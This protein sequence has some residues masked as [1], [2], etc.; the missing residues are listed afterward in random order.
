MVR[1]IFLKIKEQLDDESHPIVWIILRFQDAFKR[2]VEAEIAQI[3]TECMD[4]EDT[5]RNQNVVSMPQSVP[6]FRSHETI[7]ERTEAEMKRIYN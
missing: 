1:Q 7:D 5:M 3:R 2:Q 6:R 4:E